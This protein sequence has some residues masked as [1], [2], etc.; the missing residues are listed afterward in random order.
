MI[1][2]LRRSQDWY[3]HANSDNVDAEPDEPRSC[4]FCTRP[5]TIVVGREMFCAKCLLASHIDEYGERYSL[6]EGAD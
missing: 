3:D 5:A 2:G 6:A 1:R 4:D